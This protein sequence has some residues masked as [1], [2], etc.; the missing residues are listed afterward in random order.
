MEHTSIGLW[1]RFH[2]A[3]PRKEDPFPQTFFTQMKALTAHS[4]AL[5]II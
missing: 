3:M 1:E 4:H 2:L 5:F